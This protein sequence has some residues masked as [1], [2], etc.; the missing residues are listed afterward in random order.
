VGSE[1]DVDGTTQVITIL[2]LL[3]AMAVSVVVTQF[4]RR[5]RTLAALRPI[6][7]YQAIPLRVG[8]AIEANRPLHVSFGHAS[9]GGDNTLL[10]LASAELFYQA[11][12]RAAIG[13]APPILTM[14]D[15]TAIPLGQDTLRRAYQSRGLLERYPRG[16]VRWYPAGARSLAF[17]AVLTAT[18]GDD[19][20]ASNVLVGSF[21]PEVALVAEAAVRRDQ[22]VI[23]ASDQLAGQAVAFALSDEPLIGEEIFTAGAYLGESASQVGLVVTLDVLRLLLIL[24]MLVPTAIAVG[25][26]ILDGR[27]SAAITRLLGGG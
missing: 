9:L 14:S 16:R 25:D 20:V 21:G 15:T 17:A 18:L 12:A 11:A 26:A 5:R 10:A 4:I 1:D 13:A 2:I 22:G 23:A 6:A 7:A 8:E 27:F 19:R 24:A 3:L